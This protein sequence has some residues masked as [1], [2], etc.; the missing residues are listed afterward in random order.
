MMHMAKQEK[1]MGRTESDAGLVGSGD[2]VLVTGAAGFIGFRVVE[3]L[4]ADPP[5]SRN[6]RCL[7]RRSSAVDRLKALAYSH[8]GARVEVIEG[9]LLSREDCAVATKNV[10]LIYHLAAGR[11]EKSYPD[12]FMNSVVTTRN[13]LDASIQHGCLKRFVNV[14]SFTV[15]SKDRKSGGLLDESCPIET[16]PALR[17]EAYCFAKVKREELVID[18]GKRLGLPYVIVRPGSVYGPPDG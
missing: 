17:G 1:D 10:K 6:V 8:E 9:N 2:Q 14:S 18:Y 12:A 3:D 11:G 13:L 4:L 15:Y 7:V 5:G 16:Q